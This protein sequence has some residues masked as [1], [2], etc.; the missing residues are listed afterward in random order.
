MVCR[1]VYVESLRLGALR[2]LV[3]FRAAED[4]HGGGLPL[5]T[6]AGG[7]RAG[8]AAAAAAAARMPLLAVAEALKALVR[9]TGRLAGT[10]APRTQ[11]QLRLTK[12]AWQAGN[13]GES[14]GQAAIEQRFSP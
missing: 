2:L 8:G 1:W 14:L 4:A 12:Q 7:G 5:L 13:S 6:D 11:G 3:T 9:A 10:T